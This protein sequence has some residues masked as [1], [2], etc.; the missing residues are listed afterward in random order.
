MNSIR[1]IATCTKNNRRLARFYRL[2]FGIDELWNE[3]QNSPYSFYISDGFIN[4]NCLLVH[5][6][7]KRNPG[8][9]LEHFGF[10]VND[11]KETENKIRAFKSSTKIEESPR[12]GRYE[13]K[14]F[15]DPEGNRLEIANNVWGTEGIKRTPGIRHIAIHAKDPERLSDFYKSVFAMKEAGKTVT[16]DTD[17]TVLYLSDGA[18]SLSLIKNAP[19]ATF[20]IQLFG[21]QVESI[22]QVQERLKKSPPF[23]YNGE[24]AVEIIRRPKK[25]PFS[26][27]YLRDPDGNYVDLSEEGWPV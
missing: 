8:V 6:G 27:F 11:L 24:P 15:H 16:K 17:S 19:V 13:D 12:D 7:M 23:L 5:P 21:I 2:L 26:S 10:Y 18:F 25:G 20:G 9:G 14:R 4:M 3:R 1:H 22:E